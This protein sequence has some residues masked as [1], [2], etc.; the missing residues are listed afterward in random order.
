MN[1]EQCIDSYSLFID[2][3]GKLQFLTEKFVLSFIRK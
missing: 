1:N 3:L 2:Y